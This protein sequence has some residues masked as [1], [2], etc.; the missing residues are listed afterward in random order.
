VG[1]WQHSQRSTER[2]PY[3]EMLEW[4]QLAKTSIVEQET[5]PALDETTNT[6]FCNHVLPTLRGLGPTNYGTLREFFEPLR[7]NPKV[8]ASDQMGRAWFITRSPYQIRPRE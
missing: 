5:I 3:A 6:N 2:H 1:R 4:L 8:I 7:F